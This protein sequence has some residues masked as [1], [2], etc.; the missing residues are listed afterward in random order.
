MKKLIVLA[1]L[2]ISTVTFGQE[3]HKEKRE[4]HKKGKMEMM[5]DLSPEQMAT[6]RTKKMILA[7]GLTK[8]QQEKIHALHLEGAKARKKH[9]KNRA[10]NR[11]VEKPK[12]SSE[13]KY[14][15]INSVL[16]RKIE[17]K[18]KMKSI[19][20]QEQFQKWERSQ[21]QSRNKKKKH[22]MRK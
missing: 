19:L 20:T 22:H 21:K 8:A 16:D 2:V 9:M 1:A 17:M 10:E 5:K 3:D 13:E 18:S 15:K 7:L 4:H 11:G 12:L 6:L 14:Q